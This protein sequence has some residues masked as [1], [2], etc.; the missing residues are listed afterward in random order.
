M[1][2]FGK[3][4]PRKSTQRIVVGVGD[5]VVSNETRVILSTFALGSC[6]GVAAFDGKHGVGGLLHIMLPSA[7]I[8]L[9]RA[10]SQ[11]FLFADTGMERFFSMLTTMGA[12]LKSCQFALVGG[13]SIMASDGAFLIGQKNID[14]VL[15]QL[16][17]FD[18]RPSAEFLGGYTNRSMHLDLGSGK[19]EVLVS[20]QVQEVY[21]A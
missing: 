6:V 21:L 9:E 14:A 20:N 12:D 11:P 15:F 19:L 13:A 8:A 5:M 1:A 2:G 3:S 16:G 18:C 10:K 7:S 4:A 17:K